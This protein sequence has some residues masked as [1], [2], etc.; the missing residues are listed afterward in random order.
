MM[1]IRSG[2]LV[3]GSEDIPDFIDLE[4]LYNLN[5]VLLRSFLILRCLASFSKFFC[6]KLCDT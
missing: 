5:S 4:G 1:K 6:L 3:P 2:Y